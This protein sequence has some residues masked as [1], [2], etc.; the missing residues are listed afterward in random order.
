LLQ[1]TVYVR[2]PRRAGTRLPPARLGVRGAGVLAGYCYI[3]S[4]TSNTAPH[5]VTFGCGVPHA[6]EEREMSPRR[7]EPR[8][9]CQNHAIRFAGRLVGCTRGTGCATART[10]VSRLY[11]GFYDVHRVGNGTNPQ[12]CAIL[13]H[14]E[15]RRRVNSDSSEACER[16]FSGVGCGTV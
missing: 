8:V 7:T 2:I 11:E 6:A 15:T 14:F 12:K 16:R 4:E 10:R 9:K 1:R 5:F 13:C 3:S